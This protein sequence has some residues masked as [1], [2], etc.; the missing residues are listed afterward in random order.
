MCVSFGLSRFD[1]FFSLKPFRVVKYI[2]FVVLVV[3]GEVSFGFWR[4]LGDVSMSCEAM[5]T[6]KRFVIIVDDERLESFGDVN[7]W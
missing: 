6:G 4:R 3:M 1:G 5:L 7:G 2:E